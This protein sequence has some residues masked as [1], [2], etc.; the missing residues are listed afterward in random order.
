M[1][2]GFN[3]DIGEYDDFRNKILLNK[4]KKKINELKE[5]KTNYN[6][7]NNTEI[8]L[9]ILTSSEIEDNRNESKQRNT[10]INIESESPL[11]LALE[12]SKKLSSTKKNLITKSLET[13]DESASCLDKFKK[14]IYLSSHNIILIY[15]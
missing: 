13:K 10:D 11:L 1:K 2:S 7:V 4:P 15:I 5:I 12:K 14:I 8:S 9:N 6:T 3:I